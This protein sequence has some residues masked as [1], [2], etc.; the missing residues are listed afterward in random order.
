[1]EAAFTYLSSSSAVIGGTTQIA[2]KIAESKA[3][4][5]ST[6]AQLTS[7]MSAF[8]LSFQEFFSTL[9]DLVKTTK[10]GVDLIHMVFDSHKHGKNDLLQAGSSVLLNALSTLKGAAKTARAI[11]ETLGG[12]VTS[13]FSQAAST[14]AVGIDIAIS[15]I[16]T[17]MQSYYLAKSAYQWWNMSRREGELKS[18]LK[19]QGY[20]EKQIKDVKDIHARRD[21]MQAELDQL[22]AK[23]ERKIA[24]KNKRIKRLS[25]RAKPTTKRQSQI[26][27]LKTEIEALRQQNDAYKQ[28]KGK[29][30]QETAK[31]ESSAISAS[32]EGLSDAGPSQTLD[33]AEVELVGELRYV[34]KKR[35]L[36]QSVHIIT[37][38]AQIAGSIATLVSGP[39]APAPLALKASA[40]GIDLSLPFFRAIKQ[41]GRNTAAKNRAKGTSGISNKIFNA[42]KSTAAKLQM[43]K[44]QAVRIL[45]M[46]TQLNDLIPTTQDPKEYKRQVDALKAQAERVESYIVATGCDPEKLYRANG[47]PAEQIKILVEE[48]ARREFL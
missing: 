8:S 19:A 46:V 31:Q 44:R 26:D 1:V 45:T 30:E 38:L 7:G 34:N 27:N 6:G 37:N 20:V 12:G 39:G 28:K 4:E 47:K 15:A 24:G 3:G 9:A 10:S 43:R 41:F 35:V 5:E 29:V 23:N 18:D 14:I 16:K 48:L 40:A 22:I 36:R 13:A 33:L 11:N 17:V 21:A 25:G 2:S 42:D 32:E